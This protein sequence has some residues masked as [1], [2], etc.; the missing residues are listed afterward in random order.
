MSSKKLEIN[1]NDLIRIMQIV[2][3]ERDLYAKCDENKPISKT[4]ITIDTEGILR[5]LNETMKSVGIENFSID[6]GNIPTALEYKKG[7]TMKKIMQNAL[8]EK[9]IT[10]QEVKEAEKALSNENVK[11]EGKEEHD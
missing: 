8:L 5:K 3:E 10:M 4:A 11:E 1:D 6:L 9:G 2:L 7:V